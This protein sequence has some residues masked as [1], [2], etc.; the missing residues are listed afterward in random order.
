LATKSGSRSLEIGPGAVR[1]ILYQGDPDQAKSERRPGN[2]NTGT[3][4]LTQVSTNLGG[5]ISGKFTINT[6]AFEEEKKP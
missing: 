1:A 5:T 4:E 2:Q 6:T 3:L